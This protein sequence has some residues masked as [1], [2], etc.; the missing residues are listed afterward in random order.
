MFFKKLPLET[1]TTWFI[2]VNVLDV[3]LTAAL[4][5]QTGIVESNPVARYFLNHWGVSGMNYFKFAVVT[6]V[7]VTAQVIAA[8]DL[9]T[10]RML[11]IG[12]T[13]VVGGVVVYSMMLLAG[14]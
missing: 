9:R 14:T 13:I 2:L 3:I 1:E 6:F 11:L 4:I 10:A 5:S 12:G 7:V 8:F